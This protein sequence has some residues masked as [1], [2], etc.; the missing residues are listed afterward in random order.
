M[1]FADAD[2][3]RHFFNA[4]GKVRIVTVGTT[5]GSTNPKD[6]SFIDLGTALGNID[7]GSQSSTR[8]GSGESLT[9]DGLANGFH[10]I[11]TSK[12]SDH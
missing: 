9:T 4:G 3:M 5:Q 7:I 8:S 6:Q 11:G 1:T 10:D 2:T 12:R